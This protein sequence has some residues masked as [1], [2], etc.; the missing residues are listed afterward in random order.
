[1]REPAPGARV[2][3]AAL[4]LIEVGASAGLCLS[5]DRYRYDDLPPVGLVDSPV[6]LTCRTNGRVPVPE[7][8]PDV[9]WRAGI[10]LDPVDVVR[11]A[12]PRRGATGLRA[13]AQRARAPAGP[14]RARHRLPRHPGGPSTGPGCAL[15]VRARRIIPRRG[16]HV[17]R[18]RR[19]ARRGRIPHMAGG[20]R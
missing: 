15:P 11:A 18:P 3:A 10:D 7:R 9:V 5:P 16:R 13:P 19:R 8:V 1:M 14:G 4:A 20:H 12:V 17:R 2:P 6:V